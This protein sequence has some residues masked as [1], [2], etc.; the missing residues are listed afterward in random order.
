MGDKSNWKNKNRTI[1]KF[2]KDFAAPWDRD[3]EVIPELKALAEGTKKVGKD[4]KKF[5]TLKSPP[6]GSRI[7]IRIKVPKRK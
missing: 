7:P 6:S 5:R 4:Q 3:A 2:K 1:A